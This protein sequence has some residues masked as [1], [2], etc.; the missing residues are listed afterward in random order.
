MER[1][2]KN[3][4]TLDVQKWVLKVQ[5]RITL[6]LVLVFLGLILFAMF[7]DAE[8]A[9]NI[10]LTFLP[11]ITGWL[12]IVLGFY[13]SR[14]ISKFLEQKLENLLKEE[15]DQ[16]EGYEDALDKIE[17]ERE[18]ERK[19]FEEII[20]SRETLIDRLRENLHRLIKEKHKHGR[21]KKRR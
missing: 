16:I 15:T 2:N 8:R 12:G 6:F 4:K 17:R 18:Q 20:N 1:S 19:K 13:F 9:N 5:G 14:E 3:K 21:D 11:I 10:I 7:G